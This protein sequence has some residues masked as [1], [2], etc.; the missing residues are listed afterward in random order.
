MTTSSPTLSARLA[1]DSRCPA[2][3]G[4]GRRGRGTCSSCRGSGAADL[5]HPRIRFNWGYHDAHLD[6]TLK[7]G[8]R[9]VVERGPQTTRTVSAEANFWYAAGYRAGLAAVSAGTYRNDSEPA[10]VE[11]TGSAER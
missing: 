6:G 7:S 9:E 4:T 8:A 10:W 1:R 5:T 3:R 11:L 2:C